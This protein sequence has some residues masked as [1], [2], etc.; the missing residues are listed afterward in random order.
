MPTLLTL[1]EIPGI[2]IALAIGMFQLARQRNLAGPIDGASTKYS[3]K[4]LMHELFTSRSMLLLVGGLVIGTLAGEK[5]WKPVQPLF[6]GLF[7]GLLCLFLLE[8]GMIAGSR[9]GD[10]RKTGLFLMAFGVLVPILHGTTGVYLGWLSG[11]SVGGC[12]VLGTMA[13][14][15]S[16]IAAPPAVRLTLP[17]ANPTFYLTS[18]LAITFPFNLLAGI[19]LYY[20]L[21]NYV[22]LQ[23]P[24]I[25]CN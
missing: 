24:A 16:Y 21:A 6:E 1:L 13:A 7:K 19:P 14:S 22:C 4:A 12:T 3:K 23:A 18:A 25:P 2:Q 17:D 10:L 15:A 5:G 8:M 20:S 11:L 9:V